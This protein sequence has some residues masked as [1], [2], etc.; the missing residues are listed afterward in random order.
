MIRFTIPGP[1]VPQGRPRLTTRGGHPHAY[2][3]AKSREYKRLVQTVAKAAMREH[4]AV[5]LEGPVMLSVQ[6]FRAIPQSWS[7][8]KR[9]AALEGSIFPTTKPDTSNVVK[10]IEDA[11]NGIVWHDDAQVV[12]TRTLKIYDEIPRVEVEVKEVEL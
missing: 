7:R 8:K 11:M 9:E 10:G 5:M 1:A 2:D 3:P 6:E 4:G 12:I